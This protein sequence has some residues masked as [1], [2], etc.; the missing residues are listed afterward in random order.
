MANSSDQD[1]D[2]IRAVINRVLNT[3]QESGGSRG[4]ARA[5]ILIHAIGVF[6]VRGLERTTVQDL[7]DAAGVSRRTFYKYFQNK[8]DVLEKLYIFSIENMILQFRQS[9]ERS[10]SVEDVIARSCSLYFDYHLGMGPIIRLMMEEARRANSVLAPHRDTAY[11]TV[12]E[13][14]RAEMYRHTGRDLDIMLYMGLIWLLE[15]YSSHLLAKPEYSPQEI[16]H[17]KR[18]VSGIVEAV[19]IGKADF[20]KL[21]THA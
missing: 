1:I 13:V 11:R 5:E 10:R 7:L 17:Y 2:K 4:K 6:S 16:E 18:I 20:Q 12:A 21:Q 19:L 8:E 15:S 3:R 9:T 14:M